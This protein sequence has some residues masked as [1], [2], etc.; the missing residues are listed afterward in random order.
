MFHVLYADSSKLHVRHD[1]T[2]FIT[3][4][5]GCPHLDNPWFPVVFRLQFWMPY[6]SFQD[7]LP[8][9]KIVHSWR[10]GEKEMLMHSITL[11]LLLRFSSF[12]PIFVKRLVIWWSFGEH[13]NLWRDNASHFHCF[14]K[15]GSTFLYH[16]FEFAPYTAEEASVHSHEYAQAGLSGCVGSSNATHIEGR[17]PLETESPRL[18]AFPHCEELL[19]HYN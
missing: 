11:P 19:Q 7:L 18:Q 12:V 2:R 17:A 14:I 16:K 4:M 10:D 9:L 1:W 13:R 3:Y 8:L 5:V 15:F 6:S